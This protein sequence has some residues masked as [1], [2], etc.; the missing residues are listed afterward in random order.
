[1]DKQFL[2]CSITS[3]VQLISLLS[4]LMEIFILFPGFVSDG[5]FNSLRTQ[6]SEQPV[7]VIQIMMDVKNKARALSAKQIEKF[8]LPVERGIY[9]YTLFFVLYVTVYFI[10]SLRFTRDMKSLYRYE[11]NVND[12][13]EHK[14]RATVDKTD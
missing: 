4:F 2:Y 10:F 8:F 11:H 3:I 13:Q 6:G 12:P 7:S 9:I 5:E 14:I 1:M